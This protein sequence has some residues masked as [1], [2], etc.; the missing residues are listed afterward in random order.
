M[1]NLKSKQQTYIVVGL[2]VALF[3][4]ILAFEKGEEIGRAIAFS[5]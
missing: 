3:I 5:S 4:L 2:G 1:E